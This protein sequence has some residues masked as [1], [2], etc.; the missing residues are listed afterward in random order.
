MLMQALLH[1]CDVKLELSKT[2]FDAHRVKVG[3][4]F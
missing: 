1:I 2:R 4:Y 3:L